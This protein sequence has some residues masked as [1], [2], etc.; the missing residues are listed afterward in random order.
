MIR[1]SPPWL[2]EYILSSD[3]LEDR[4]AF[5]QSVAAAFYESARVL[6]ERSNPTYVVAS[7]QCEAALVSEAARDAYGLAYY[8]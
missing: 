1:L 5:L 6:Y 8:R 4:A 7:L 3:R 2:I